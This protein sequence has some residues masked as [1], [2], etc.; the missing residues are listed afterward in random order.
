MSRH[1]NAL[2]LIPEQLQQLRQR[3]QRSLENSGPSAETAELFEAL[4]RANPD[5]GMAW[6]NLGDALRSI[7][8]L[9][10][11]EEALLTARELA[12]KSHRFT[13]DARLGMVVSKSGSPADAEKWFRLATSDGECPGWVWVLRAANLIRKE[14]TKLARECLKAAKHRDEVDLEE[15]LLNEA[16][17]E[18]CEGNYEAAARCAEDALKID[19]NYEP[20]QELLVS[21]RGG[22]E[23][24]S[25]INRLLAAS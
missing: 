24:K 13:V 4:V 14:S 1:E 11:A 18:R 2:R 20:A 10:E 6:F 21:I 3:A 15:V 19:P 7:G 5:D 16:L 23:A 12:P 8:R 9:K 25:Y 17:I 22:A